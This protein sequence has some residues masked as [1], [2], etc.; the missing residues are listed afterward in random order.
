MPQ[1]GI[2]VLAAPCIPIASI[3]SQGRQQALQ[4]TF[5]IDPQGAVVTDSDS[6]RTRQLFRK[7]GYNRGFIVARQIRMSCQRVS[8]LPI[9]ENLDP[10]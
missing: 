4:I 7:F 3:V 2:G 10:V 1:T 8:L 9:H 6:L 5:G